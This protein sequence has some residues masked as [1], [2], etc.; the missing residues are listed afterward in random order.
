MPRSKGY[1]HTAKTLRLMSLR[2]SGENNPFYGRKHALDSRKKISRA[3]RGAKNPMHG[4][5]HKEETKRKI[6][7]AHLRRLKRTSR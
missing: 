7:L 1:K 6:R 3:L 4:K 5:R 2:A